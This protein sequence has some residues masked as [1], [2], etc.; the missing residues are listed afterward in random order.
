ME[1]RRKFL[2]MMG[3][4]GMSSSATAFAGEATVGD[5]ASSGSL[6]AALKSKAAPV[7]T[8]DF[9]S[10]DFTDLEPLGY[11]VASARLVQLGEPS[12]GSG[13]AFAAK[14]RIVKFLHQR[15]GFDVLI[16]ESGMYDVSLAQAEMCSTSSDAVTAAQK[17][18]FTLWSGAAEV[19]PLFEYIK[20]SQSTLHPLEIAGFDI[21]VT[22]DRTTERFAQDLHAFVGALNDP[23]IRES[24]VSMADDATGARNRL[25][26]SKFSNAH[27]LEALTDAVQRLR[28]LISTK[29]TA[30][31]AISSDLNLSFWNHILENMRAD[32]ALRAESA[33]SPVTT[34]VRESGRDALNAANLRWLLDERY[35]GRKVLVWAH[36]VH[37]MN[38]YYAPGFRD[39][40][41]VQ[42]RDD[43]KTT[44]VFMK[45]W[46]GDKVYT[47]GMT[48]FGGQEGFAMGGPR[49]TIASAP[50]GS[51]E[52]NLHSLGY[53][54]AFLDLQ[55]VRKD[56]SSPLRGR[57]AVRTPK[58]DINN[59]SDLGHIYDGLFFIDQMAA[60]TRV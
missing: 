19:K 7:R 31:Q 45:E 48:T 55:S 34:T 25:Y 52:A 57:L 1:S 40:H 32:A 35:A 27:D 6:H 39:V 49:M 11:A 58:F 50:D 4:M 3:A 9:T 12:H 8:L 20:V 47:I 51:L 60:A 59:V 56:S 43:M 2:Y 38:A 54:V 36:N 22:A 24:A 29:R 26:S 41:L 37:V 42:R 13:S 14:A 53:P 44:G 23:K 17:G 15:H 28:A 33:K 5:E 18:I 21:Q 30:F 10:D 16:W 46:L